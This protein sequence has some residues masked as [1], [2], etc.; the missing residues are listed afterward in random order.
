MVVSALVVCAGGFYRVEYMPNFNL[1]RCENSVM[2]ACDIIHKP[3]FAIC[4]RHTGI[5]RTF[6]FT[7]PV[8]ENS[9]SSH[10]S[11]LAHKKRK[12]ECPTTLGISVPSAVLT[13]V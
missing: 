13:H 3:F 9:S 10:I 2:S 7:F 5:L 4:L 12:K 11:T 1:H 8:T 6:L